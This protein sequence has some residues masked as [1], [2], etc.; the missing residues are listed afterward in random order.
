MV[1][2]F[3]QVTNNKKKN[4]KKNKLPPIWM[5]TFSCLDAKDES[6]LDEGNKNVGNFQRL[7]NKSMILKEKIAIQ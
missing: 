7:G 4:L 2:G 5:L 6:C 1:D 3:A